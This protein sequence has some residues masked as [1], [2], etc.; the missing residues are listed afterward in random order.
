M[1]REGTVL[2]PEMEEIEENLKTK[3]NFQD[4]E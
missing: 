2:P 1:K 4:S 3:K